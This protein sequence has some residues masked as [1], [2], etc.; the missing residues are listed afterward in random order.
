ML[1]TL[2][3]EMQ[4]AKRL[5]TNDESL[6]CLFECVVRG[7][8]WR[9]INLKNLKEWEMLAEERRATTTI[10]NAFRADRHYSG[11]NYSSLKIYCKITKLLTFFKL[12]LADLAFVADVSI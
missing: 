4:K 3:A 2:L 5:R 9:S 6:C 10:F 12:S 1:G 7:K 11:S 8:Q